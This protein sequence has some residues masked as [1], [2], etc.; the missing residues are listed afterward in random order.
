MN[1]PVRASYL[2]REV[3]Q[4]TIFEA[5]LN[6]PGFTEWGYGLRQARVLDATGLAEAQEVAPGAK[7]EFVLSAAGFTHQVTSTITKIDVPHLIEWDYTDGAVGIGGWRLED[8]IGAVRMTLHTDYEVKP[9]WLNRIAHRP[10]FRGLTESLL[11]R[12]MKRFEE[13]LKSG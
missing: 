8:E 10:F 11:R 6:V 3:D 2:I 1:R 4:Q 7:F 12:S 5:L 9:A 13:R